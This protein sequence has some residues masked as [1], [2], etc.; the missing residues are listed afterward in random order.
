MG[1]SEQ[2]QQREINK[3]LK[4]NRAAKSYALRQNKEDPALKKIQKVQRPK[5]I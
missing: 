2:V 5:R 1:E 4:E 3:L